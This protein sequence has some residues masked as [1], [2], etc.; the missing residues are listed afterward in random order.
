MG[1]PDKY[2]SRVPSLESTSS[3]TLY[4]SKQLRS[5]LKQADSSAAGAPRVT[6][7]GITYRLIWA[8]TSLGG[9]LRS[10]S[11]PRHIPSRV[12]LQTFP[13]IGCKV[14]HRTDNEKEA[15][16]ARGAGVT[17]AEK[18]WLMRSYFTKCT[19]PLVTVT[20]GNASEY[21]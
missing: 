14:F 3:V 2:Y 21:P 11:R 7:R 13:T 5:E 8:R 12:M 18:T 1:L 10:R 15:V 9:H 16:S 19:A 4:P 6:P 17:S 20:T